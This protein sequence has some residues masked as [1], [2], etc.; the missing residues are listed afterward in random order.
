MAGRLTAE[1]KR[2]VSTS[3]GRSTLLRPAASAPCSP[4]HRGRLRRSLA[5]AWQQCLPAYRR[6]WARGGGGCWAR[7]G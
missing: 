7:G 2:L 3:V 6:S 5:D 4:D 1:G